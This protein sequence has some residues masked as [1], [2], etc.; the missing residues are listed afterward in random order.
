MAR[1]KIRF[2]NAIQKVGIGS[3]KGY[4]L[5]GQVYL[6]GFFEDYIKQYK[7]NRINWKYYAVK[8]LSRVRLFATPWAVAYQAPLSMGFSRQQSW[9][10]LPFPSPGDL[11]K[12]G[13]EPR[14]PALQT[15]AL[16]S[17]PPGKSPKYYVSISNYYNNASFLDLVLYITA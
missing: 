8:S 4:K 12:P 16:P 6:T 11:P 1:H 14:S 9:S 13:I 10:G 2:Q 3:L 5:S 7:K 17:E 15:D